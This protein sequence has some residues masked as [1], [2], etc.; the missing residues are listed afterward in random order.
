MDDKIY[1]QIFLKPRFRL[2]YQMNSEALLEEIKKHLN[3][4]SKYKMKVVD[5]HV[6]VDVPEKESHIW[7]PQLHLEIEKISETTSHIKGLFGPKPQV[8]TFFMFLH[9]LVGTAFV[10][11]GIVAYSNWSL[12]QT[13]IFPI[14]MLV[15]L[16]IVW[17]TLYLI[18]SLGKSTGKE[19]MNELKEY[20]KKLLKTIKES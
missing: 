18:G 12:K 17:I 16:P 6:V 8:W 7:S 15:V 1:N 9:F 4:V 5:N 3:D 11:F 19:Q 10:I 13:S 20:T 2:D 14:V